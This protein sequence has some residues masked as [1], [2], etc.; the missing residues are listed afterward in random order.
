MASSKQLLL[1]SWLL[2]LPEFHCPWW[3]KLFNQLLASAGFEHSIGLATQL[4]HLS[5]QLL[6]LACAFYLA[7][8]W[9]SLL[10]LGTCLHWMPG[11][12][13]YCLCRLG[14][15]FGSCLWP[16]WASLYHDHSYELP[17]CLTGQAHHSAPVLRVKISSWGPIIKETRSALGTLAKDLGQHQ[18]D[19][20]SLLSSVLQGYWPQYSLKT[21]SASDLH[22][23]ILA[24]DRIT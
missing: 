12:W 4:L 13:I 21:S 14:F 11:L 22:L 6:N 8:C 20:H 5:S 2:F 24:V 10:A 7:S 17:G 9:I 3:S 18:G 23:G 15:G 19:I 16:G 1:C